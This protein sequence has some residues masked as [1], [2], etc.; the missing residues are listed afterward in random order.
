M[1]L[2]AAACSLKV[3]E[4]INR[5]AFF[6]LGFC[7][8]NVAQTRNA[9]T[10]D[11]FELQAAAVADTARVGTAGCATANPREF[12]GIGGNIFCGALLAGTNADTTAGVITC[13]NR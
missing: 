12:V 2:L 7:G 13:N 3:I 8:L 5:F 4:D 6:I 1:R 9:A 11:S 10:P